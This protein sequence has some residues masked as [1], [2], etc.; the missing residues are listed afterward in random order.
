MA[1]EYDGVPLHGALLPLVLLFS[2]GNAP[3]R[4]PEGD[5]GARSQHGKELMAAGR[6]A[7]A[8]PVYRGLVS[9][10]PDNA[11]L[12]LNLGMALHMA[13]QDGE[14]VPQFQ[15][16][17]RL[18][19]D[20]LPAALL[21]GAAHL[22]LGRPNDAVAA[23]QKAVR[24]QPDNREARS[25]LV[26]AL[27]ALERHGQAEPHLRRLSQLAPSDP[28][29][30][31]SLGQT[32]EELAGQAF[33]GL[34]KQD[35]ES[36]F[37]LALVADARLK[38][39]QRTAA[40][41]LYRLALERRP[42]LRGL[43]AAVA[44]IYRSAGYSDWAAVEEERERSLPK[45]DCARTRL[46]CD[47][48]GGKHLDVAAA[49]S[50][51]TTPEAY[52][53]RVRAYNELATQA[54]FRLAALPPSAQSH[55][56]MARSHRNE[57]QYAE[58]ADQWRRA[59]ALKPSDPRLKMELAVTL[60]LNRD[61]GAA[62]LL[63]EELLRAVPDAAEPNYL[64][65]DVLLAQEQPERA[66]PYLEKAIRLEPREP[67]ARGALGRAYALV[68]RPA[69]AIA[70]LQQALP[71]DADGSLRYQLA[72]SYQA[73]GQTE[74]A[75]AAMKDYEEFRKTAQAASEAAG[76]GASLTPP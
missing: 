74:R 75:Q 1:V 49:G 35:P 17:L 23:L 60:R 76:Q 10:L 45:P 21:L 29:V 33:A 42:S 65:G 9:A 26:D 36:P 48:A 54:F 63:L 50:N 38:Q 72:R 66:I 7:E 47:F 52:Y 73:A 19:P 22:R 2:A 40:F 51:L 59:I 13:G 8:V 62:R 55:E 15:A 58:A 46:E 6:Y 34:L 44:G 53:W 32:Y 28:A 37:A 43:H 69:D 18:Q 64:L 39:D 27:V 57:R 31:F 71:A 3:L 24:L 4:L 12:L 56:W 25:M 68:G 5:L 70:H 14:A 41:H 16:A 61:L 67:R 30:W 11:G 20:L